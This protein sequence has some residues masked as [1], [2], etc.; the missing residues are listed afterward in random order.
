[1]RHA[2]IEGESP[3]DEGQLLKYYRKSKY[4]P[5]SKVPSVWDMEYDD[6]PVIR[7]TKPGGARAAAAAILAG[8]AFPGTPAKRMSPATSW[9]DH[10]Y[11]QRKPS[12]LYTTPVEIDDL[13]SNKDWPVRETSASAAVARHILG[14]R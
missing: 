6:D 1:M 14:R 9:A 8:N 4:P 12:K 5:G 2:D 3:G 11:M 7:L 13:I 10:K